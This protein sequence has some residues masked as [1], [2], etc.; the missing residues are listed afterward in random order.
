MRKAEIGICDDHK[1]VR[2]GVRLMFHCNP[3]YKVVFEA[4][5]VVQLLDKLKAKT[6]DL[7][8]LDLNLPGASG[9]DIIE[10]LR[11]QYPDMRILVLSANYDEYSILTAIDRGVHGY[12]SKDADSHEFIQAVDAVV[13]GDEFFGDT[14]S[15]IV[16]YSFLQSTKSGSLSNDSATPD[17][18]SEREKE[19]LKCFAE[20]MS[21]KQVA[22]LLNISPRTVETHRTHIM[23]KL[24]IENLAQLVKYAIRNGIVS[25]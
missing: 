15:R 4:D 24:G 10:T 19:V 13:S 18:I 9:L 5:H 2:D 23:N 12:I 21:Y 16:Y 17:F 3:D 20:G 25:L 11:T 8:I 14:V 6:I 22:D 7:L 1:I